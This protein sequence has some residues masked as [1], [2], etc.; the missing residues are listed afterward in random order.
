ME[1]CEGNCNVS[2]IRRFREC[3]NVYH[4]KGNEGVFEDMCYE[5]RGRNEE[6]QE[7]N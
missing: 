5:L 7:V 2:F 1:G 6:S 3:K 4:M